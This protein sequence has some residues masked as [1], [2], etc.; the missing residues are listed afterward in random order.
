MGVNGEALQ[1][2][3]VNKKP[4]FFTTSH[5]RVRISTASSARIHIRYCKS[6]ENPYQ[7]LQVTCAASECALKSKDKIIITIIP[8]Y[9]GKNITRLLPLAL[10]LV[11][12]THKNTDCNKL[13]IFSG[14]A[15][16]Y[17]DTYI[18]LPCAG[19]L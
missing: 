2:H 18:V 10:L 6:H 5:A 7:V 16:Y 3:A 9:T 13:V 12:R 19:T 15:L 1:L 14:I 11:L 17:G 8:S 4:Y